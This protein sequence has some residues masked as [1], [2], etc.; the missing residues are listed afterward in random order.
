MKK[1][2]PCFFAVLLSPAIAV[3]EQTQERVVVADF[4]DVGTWRPVGNSG[5]TPG[6]WFSGATWM[7]G[8]QNAR[9][10]DDWVGE[11]RFDF[12]VET[13]APR[14]LSFRRVKMS[15]VSGMIDG[16]EFD[17]D[18]RGHPVSLR[19]ILLDNQQKRHTTPP[20]TLGPEGWRRHRL[21]FDT[22]TWPALKDVRFPASLEQVVLESA[23]GGR[24]SVFIDDLAITGTF[25]GK[26]RL[27]IS[28]VYSD[29]N[30]D[31]ETPVRL[32]YRVRNALPNP[33]AIGGRLVVKTTDGAQLFEGRSQATAPAGNQTR[34]H[35]EIPALPAGAYSAWLDVTGEGISTSYDDTFGVFLPNGARLN[36]RPMWFGVQDLTILQG[37]GENRLH[38]EWMKKIGFDL[39]RQE[40]TAGRFD[41]ANLTGLEA[42]RA[43]LQPFEEAGIDSSLLYFTTPSSLLD[44]RKDNRT[45]PTDLAVFE[46]YAADIG[47]F[48]SGFPRIKYVEFWNE[49]DI[50]FFRGTLEE[51]WSMFAAFSRGL[52]STAPNIKITTGGATVKHPRE[53]PGFSESL[54]SENGDLYDVAAFHSHG[55]LAN[56][57]ERQSLVE[58]W[59]RKGGLEKP[60][61]NTEA[62][63][64]SGYD[65]RG[66]REQ[67]VA[68]VK[69]IAYAKSRPRS[70]F[71]VWF[72]LQD[73]WDMDP[74]ADDSFGLVTSDNRAKP[75]LV[76]YNELIRRLANTT[77]ATTSSAQKDVVLLEFDRDDGKRVSVCW[78]AADGA[79]LWL[80]PAAPVAKVDLFG[81]EEI[82]RAGEECTI[83]VGDAPLYLVSDGPLTFLNKDDLPLIVPSELHRDASA[84]M[85][86]PVIVRNHATE[87]R[88]LKVELLTA[89]EKVIWSESRRFKA[90][91]PATLHARLPASSDAAGTTTTLTLRLASKRET[92]ASLPIQ[93][94][95]NHVISQEAPAL[96]R[97]ATLQD[98]HE[99]TF[100]PAIPAWNGPQDLSVDAHISRDDKSVIFRFDVM[101]DRH[102]QTHPD[103]ELWRGDSVQL[104][105]FIPG[106]GAHTLLEFALRGDEAIA[107]CRKNAVPSLHGRWTIPLKI[108]RE[109]GRTL[110]QASVPFTHLGFEHIPAEGLPVRFAFLVNDDDGQGRMRW[111]RWQGGV[112]DNQ[113]V[114]QLGRG[115]IK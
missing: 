37:E 27:R 25:S 89:N 20:V 39:N 9:F 109:N 10:A 115:I 29:I 31:L 2:L 30:Y 102:V 98:V 92:L 68:L 13:T 11:V 107:W 34:L 62:G 23:T 36:K 26:D 53:K 99:L 59:Q 79:T 32:E 86:I 110:Y 74:T 111:M 49:P 41:P 60:I 100:D 24:G 103:A 48:L 87:A 91:E 43:L 112:G 67:A 51:Y 52:R 93:V 75:A 19:F 113:D 105:F 65:A 71:Y 104:A 76:A 88:D 95:A 18:S 57:I 70:E 21:A 12:A 7:G 14:R 83:F 42:W 97:L 15:Q 69:K 47:I 96:I 61:A 17:A 55:A 106:N 72:T 90:G 4:E 56:Y 114:N 81:R 3:P 38:L 85:T 1:L 84:E 50:G 8:S 58:H 40:M 22:A 78:A 64:R 33:V 54:Y 77:P 28:P 6:A 101:D 108:S 16:I 5:S 94:R 66:R 35:F 44:Q 82:L 73:Y 46:R 45:P 80:R 63:V